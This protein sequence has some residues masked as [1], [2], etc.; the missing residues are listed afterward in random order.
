MSRLTFLSVLLC[1]FLVFE[2]L[3]VSCS[4]DDKDVMVI[5]NVFFQKISGKYLLDE[6]VDGLQSIE[7]LPSGTYIVALSYHDDATPYALT[8]FDADGQY[9]I[10]N[11]SKLN[12]LS[13]MLDGF[14]L[15]KM[16][17][18]DN[19]PTTFDLALDN[20]AYEIFHHG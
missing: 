18:T 14:G 11:Y 10:G 13:Y 20:E 8:R 12:N 4:S 19:V 5:T 2:C 15:L 6:N 3:I 7:L 16:K 17:L 1:C 9:I